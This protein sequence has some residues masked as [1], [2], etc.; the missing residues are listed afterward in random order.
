MVVDEVEVE[1]AVEEEAVAV[2]GV[3]E[4]EVEVEAGVVEEARQA[5]LTEPRKIR[6]T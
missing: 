5:K 6:T 3:V 2:A 1:D 4:E